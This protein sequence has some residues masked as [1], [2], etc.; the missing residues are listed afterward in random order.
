MPDPY[1]IDPEPVAPNLP[2][3]TVIRE[4][5]DQI[6]DALAADIYVHSLDCVRQFGDFHI[7]I[8]DGAFQQRLC[9]RL[10][11]DPAVRMLPWKRTHVWASH[12]AI[13]PDGRSSFQNI[14][15]LLADHAGIPECNL[16]A[17]DLA[18]E[19]P[20]T[21]Y[22]RRVQEALAWR[23]KGHDRLDLAVLSLSPSGCLDGIVDPGAS[24]HGA[25]LVA[26]V[27]A[28]AGPA[29]NLGFTMTSTLINVTRLIAVG[30]S[31][32]R[33]RPVL[34]QAR[35]GKPPGSQIR[36]LGGTLRWYVDREACPG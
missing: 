16:H 13:E 4:N 21:E 34:E 2:G 12:D 32:E 23:E 14:V 8:A 10:M 30:V 5:E 19:D 18:H 29:F 28:D 11:T 6:L 36:P 3:H 20:P 17:P 22:E 31:G 9:V 15:E 24:A 35:A 1:A 25:R 7:A 26:P 33:V 27:G